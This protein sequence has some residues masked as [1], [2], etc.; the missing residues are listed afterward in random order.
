MITIKQIERIKGIVGDR[1]VFHSD[2]ND[3]S[4]LVSDIERLVAVIDLET[5][6]CVESE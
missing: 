2:T 1:I 4:V 5:N 6:N 3:Y